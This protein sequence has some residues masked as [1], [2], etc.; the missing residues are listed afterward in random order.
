MLPQ[1]TE[2][3]ARASTA[4]R[5][6]IGTDR[7][8]AQWGADRRRGSREFTKPSTTLTRADAVEG[9]ATKALRP[10]V[11]LA[12]ATHRAEV[13][14]ATASAITEKAL[15]DYRE[16]RCRGAA[17]LWARATKRAGGSR[18]IVLFI[19]HLWKNHTA[20]ATAQRK[21]I[22]QI[23]QRYTLR[24]RRFLVREWR[25]V[26]RIQ[27]AERRAELE[28][29]TRQKELREAREAQ[30]GA[31]DRCAELV[32][33]VADLEKQLKASKERELTDEERAKIKTKQAQF[34]AR[35]EK[36]E[37]GLL[38]L[39]GVQALDMDALLGSGERA[40]FKSRS[41][42]SD[43]P[44]GA[45][46]YIA[47]SFISSDNVEALGAEPS[48]NLPEKILMQ[49]ANAS[50]K[51]AGL[52]GAPKSAVECLPSYVPFEDWRA[53][54]VDGRQLARIIFA[55]MEAC[56]E[57]R[58]LASVENE[59]TLPLSIAGMGPRLYRM[60]L[61]D[62]DL[63]SYASGVRSRL[64]R[65]K[66]LAT[67]VTNQAHDKLGLPPDLLDA[68]DIKTRNVDWHFPLLT[69]LMCKG[70]SR[71]SDSPDL[72]YETC[73]KQF[74]EVQTTWTS[75]RERFAIPDDGPPSEDALVELLPKTTRR[76]DHGGI[77]ELCEL[78]MD[79][80]TLAKSIAALEAEQWRSS[81]LWD[82]ARNVVEQ[83]CFAELS[84]RAREVKEWKGEIDKK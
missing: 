48:S 57:C 38:A 80:S 23:I 83:K 78:A 72:T 17:W 50:S 55:E 19:L 26:A 1:L 16:A 34:R 60:R 79:A 58:A 46:R 14:L 42:P 76:S 10:P 54:F 66:D 28:E 43:E 51:R 37:N 41:Y 75:L 30:Q 9:R 12:D 81:V 18:T 63:L 62:R 64:A 52:G 4:T 29:E 2:Q 5:G 82:R 32:A 27:R 45:P 36:A 33:K 67:W 35:A 20:E 65:P 53:A 7:G 84:R 44:A 24:R 70:C 77:G 3:P 74:G 31:E 6:L 68:E 47:P 22:E 61:K 39:V 25:R 49:W 59:E 73:S 15:L 69:Y 21:H 40:L 71:V 56:L 8:P 13:S 11:D